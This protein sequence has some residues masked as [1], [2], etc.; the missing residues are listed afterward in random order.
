MSPDSIFTM[1]SDGSSQTRFPTTCAA[2][3]CLGDSSP[4]WSP[5]GNQLVFERAFGP[6]VKDSAAGLDLVTA[7][8]DGQQRAS[9]P[10]L[11]FPGGSGQGAA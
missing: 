8:A 1:G 11:P 7:S 6:I 4:A 3:S 9:D 5:D 2:P 10:S